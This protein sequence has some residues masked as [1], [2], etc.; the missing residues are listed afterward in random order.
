MARRFGNTWWGQA[1]LEAL[2]QRALED[3]NRL[4][5]G[6]TYA[7]QGRV[8]DVVLSPGE[9]QANVEGTN[10]Y[11]T[12]LSIRVIDDLGWSDIIEVIT[13]KV[14]NVA[15]LLAG[16]V[17]RDLAGLVLPSRGDLGPECNCPD[18]AELCKHSAALCYVAADIFD[19]DPFALLTLRGRNRQDVLAKVRESRA[20]ML[21]VG[22]APPSESPRGSDPG[23][24]AAAAF[25]RM[26]PE[27]IDL[28]SRLRV[29]AR[30]SQMTPLAHAP[31][32]DSGIDPGDLK[33]LVD[34]AA[35]RAWNML[36]KGASSALGLKPGEDV[37]RRAVHAD[38]V[39]IAAEVGVD[40]N[41]LAAAVRAYEVGG[42]DAVRVLRDRWEPPESE[43]DAAAGLFGQSPT[44][45]ANRVTLGQRQLRL[46]PN[47]IWWHFVLDPELGWLPDGNRSREV[48]ELAESAEPASTD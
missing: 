48:A 9:I 11:S 37:I 22:A 45:R 20:L 31:P 33:S 21:G 40:H 29:P 41:E 32:P 18:W 42:V 14:A 26:Q 34:D 30:P 28:S 19:L 3:P 44:I 27:L 8:S 10:L 1:W 46:A 5:R 38:P 2:E 12:A 47:L 16:E 25:K 17:P 43:M 35:R 23:V 24:S 39:E 15:A 36:A 7:R 13:A 6:R 4:P